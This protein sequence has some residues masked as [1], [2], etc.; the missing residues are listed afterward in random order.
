[1]VRAIIIV[2]VALFSSSAL[3]GEDCTCSHKGAKIPEGQKACIKTS[4]GMQMA[5]C[6]RVLNNTSWKFLGT[7]CPTAQMNNDQKQTDF[8]LNT[9]KAYLKNLG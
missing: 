3:A 8:N 2:G 4:N 5:Q 1:M 6:S 7:P 9:A